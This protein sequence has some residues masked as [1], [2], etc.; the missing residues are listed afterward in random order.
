[1]KILNLLLAAMFTLFAAWQYNDP[2][3]WRWAAM[4]GFVAVVCGFAAFGK[5]NKY[6]LWAGIAV[7]LVWMVVWVPEFIEW[8]KIGRPNIAGQMK[9]ETPYIEYTREFLGLAICGA[10]LGWQLWRVRKR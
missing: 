4:Y 1:M 2:D 10:V 5:T 6:A 3:P 7:C 8:V 9:A